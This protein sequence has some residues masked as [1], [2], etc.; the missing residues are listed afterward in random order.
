MATISRIMDS[1]V[2]YGTPG[3]TAPGDTVP[4]ATAP[5]NTVAPPPAASPG[6]DYNP[7]RPN[8]DRPN[9]WV[10]VLVDCPQIQGLF[11]Y[12]I[13]PH[14]PVAIGDILTVPFGHQQLGAIAIALPSAPPPDLSPSQIKTVID[15]VNPGFFPRHY[16]DLLRQ[17]AQYY[18]TPIMAVIRT[19]LPPGLLGRSQRRIRLNAPAIP[20]DAEVFLRP[21]ALQLLQLLRQ[22]KTGEY[23]WRYLQQQMPTAQRGLPDLLQRGW[24]SSYLEP[25]NPPRPK[26]QKAVT[27]VRQPDPTEPLT[28]RQRQLLASLGRS[29]GDLWLSHLLQ[30]CHASSSIV[31]TLAKKGFVVI[32][33]RE[34]L[35]SEAEHPLDRD[36]P[37]ALSPHQA[38]AL[39]YI[40]GL[41]QAQTVLL[42]GVTGSG[43]TE[44]Y[45]QAIAPVL[46]RGQS[47]LV[48]V[49][50]IGL[51]PQLTDRF[52]Q[53]FGSQ[54]CV[55][56]SALSDGERYDTWRQMLQGDPQV[57]IGTRSAVFAPLPH[58]GLVILDEEHDSSFKQ[59]QPQPCYHART[60]AQWRSQLAPCPL[61]LG[62]ATPALE[63]WHQ[64]FSDP[65]EGHP[66]PSHYLSLPSRIYDRP[67]PQIRVID[68]R[69]EFHCGNRS[70]FSRSLR[71]ALETL[72]ETGQQGL[73]FVPRRGHSTF[74][75]CRSCGEALDC[76]HCDVSLSHH[77]PHGGARSLLRCHYCHYA[78]V[79]PEQCPHCGSPYLKFFGSGTQRVTQEL[80]RHLPDLRWIRF[81]SDTTRTKGAHRALLT[82]FAQGE[83]DILVGT[84]MLT[85]GIDLPQVTL[86][87]VM[88]AD[89]L[90]HLPDFRAGEQACQ[91]LLQ[92][93]GR[94]GRGAEPGQVILQT[95][96]P[97]HEVIAAVVRQGYGDYLAQ[98]LAQRSP[99]HYPPYSQLV[100][101][102]ISSLEA[103]RTAQVAEA[104][105]QFLTSRLPESVLLL[106][107]A[108]AP[109][110]RV[111]R[112]F[113]WHLLLKLCD[114]SLGLDWF[115]AL[116]LQQRC[117]PGVALTIDVDPLS[118][119]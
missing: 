38:A 8:P 110:L 12:A 26:Q 35:R 108:P 51:T 20:P 115:P 82:Q 80:E 111:A 54:V 23:S 21:A 83:A 49:P 60:V 43:K 104:L 116:E 113:R 27:L 11:T 97:D 55:Y 101:L 100:L 22:S 29:G 6:A 17:V 103:D 40:Q 18:C 112:R 61:I 14:L 93:A 41:T 62:S 3:D 106:G 109:I 72:R 39:A 42:H 90:F 68:M 89:G 56:H 46:Q 91:T 53:R 10:E 102:R 119:S 76:P 5:G 13:P 58:L 1:A 71:N 16:W 44:V 75:S 36:Q 98:E 74:V 95:Y 107:P 118:L 70:I 94:A 81:D 105:G 24:V 84:Q 88:A 85:K 92:V 47:A 63:T 2:G 34:N 77:Q 28:E 87:G 45:L 117:G 31:T 78:S 50:E 9:P 73:L 114:P 99:L 66:P 48:L 65:R 37:K 79:Q 7:D 19:A 25:P 67:Q 59:S 15:I 32:Q 57:V 96:K 52:R 30:Q 33:E 86:V 64:A 69:Q 4:E